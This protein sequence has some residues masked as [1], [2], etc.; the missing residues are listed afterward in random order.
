MSACHELGH[1]L[2]FRHQDLPYYQDFAE[3]CMRNPWLEWDLRNDGWRDYNGDHRDH[4]NAH[5]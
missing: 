5:L 3:D 4:I 1:S 2:G